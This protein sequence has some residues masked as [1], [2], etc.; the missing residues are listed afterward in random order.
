MRLADL[1]GHWALVTGASSGIGREF[2]VQLGQAGVNLLL[3]ARNAVALESLA[4]ELRGLGV[5]V[6]PVALNLAGHGASKELW[7]RVQDENI[8]IRLL[9]NN[10]AVGSWA[11]FEA[12]EAAR[13]EALIELNITTMVSL[14]RHFMADLA[15]HASS[16]IINVSSPAAYQPVP[17]MAVY[18]A[19]KAFVQ[20]FSLALHEEG[21]AR[22]ILV[23]TLVPGPS[24]T[25]LEGSRVALRGGMAKQIVPPSTPVARS[26]AALE[27]GSA[28]VVAAQ[29]GLVQRLFA[30]LPAA[31]VIRQVGK[32]FVPPQA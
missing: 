1:K 22:G 6:I 18:A 11:A 13:Y 7:Q 16:C 19:S 31:F 4:A 9:V 25:N 23:Q 30:L 15:Q 29:G 24:L 10:A 20:N 21:R 2:A 5:R 28:L 26:L 14:C 3:V 12:A 17:H 27:K 8:T 32:F